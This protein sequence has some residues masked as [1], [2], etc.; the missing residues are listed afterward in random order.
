ML[1]MADSAVVFFSRDGNTR[2][3]AEI[4][5]RKLGAKLIELQEERP[6]NALH[7]LF[8]MRTPLKGDPWAEIASAKR[9]YLLCPIWAG[10]SVPAMNA[11]A[12]GADFTGKAV[13]IITFQQGPS[14]QGHREQ[15]HLAGIVTRNHGSVRDCYSLVG[16]KMRQFAGEAFIRAQI[17]VVRLPGE[18]SDEVPDEVPEELPGEEP[19]EVPEEALGEEPGEKPEEVP[20]GAPGEA[21]DEA[22]D[23]EPGE[24]PEEV[25]DEAPDEAPDEVAGEEPGE[26]PDE[27]PDE[28]AGE[29]PGEL[30][31]EVPDG[32]P[33]EAPDEVPDEAPGELPDEVPGELPGEL[34]DE[35]LGELPDE[36]PEELPDETPDE[37]P[38]EA[39]E[40]E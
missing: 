17:D 31:E 12:E 37:T 38:G 23:E 6:G 8:R 33:G 22:P 15:R 16:G 32:A 3:G 34:P 10:S 2:C 7:A 35:A 30:P 40:K 18:E 29:E 36:A 21:P 5:S 14:K 13:E 11:F 39:P 26:L 20:D 9:V 27:A 1:N 24:K 25:P 4:L 19:G 28:V